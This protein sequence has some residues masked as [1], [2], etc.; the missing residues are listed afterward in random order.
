MDPAW[1]AP[2]VATRHALYALSPADSGRSSLVYSGLPQAASHAPAPR[3]LVG[4]APVQSD[5]VDACC[6]PRVAERLAHFRGCALA[7]GRDLTP[8]PGGGVGASALG[9]DP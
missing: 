8:T 4:H 2:A 6:T 7:P 3:T 9:V 1:A 5:A